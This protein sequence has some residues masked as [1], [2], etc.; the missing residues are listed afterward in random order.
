M[1]VING[2]WAGIDELGMNMYMKYDLRG[3]LYIGMRL[4]CMI[5][6]CLVGEA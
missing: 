3:W 4:V 2:L 1:H 5:I 6:L